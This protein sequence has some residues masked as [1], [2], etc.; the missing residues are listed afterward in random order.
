MSPSRTLGIELGLALVCL[1]CQTSRPKPSSP[2]V[3]PRA[4]AQSDELSQLQALEDRRS[5][6]DGKVAQWALTATDPRVRT[7]ALLALARIQDGSSV[8]TVVQA[9]GDAAPGPRLE[10]AFAAGILGRSWVA[11]SPAARDRLAAA[12]LT[13][14]A[15]ELD[16]PAKLTELEALGRVPTAAALERL[17]DRLDGT[18]PDVKAQAALSLGLA[19]KFEG[20]LPARVLAALVP[21]VRKDAPPTV[22]RA[23][24]YAFALSKAPG[25]R[26][27]LLVCLQDELPEVRALCA[28]GLGDVGTEPDAVPLK[29]LLGDSDYR[30]AVEATR[31]LAK[32]V[33]RCKTA[34]ACPGIAALG[35]LSARVQRLAQ[36]DSAGGG[37]PLLAL[38]QEGLP[39]SG[40][41]VLMAVRAKVQDALL[42]ATDARA[43]KDLAKIDCRLAAALDR[44]VG[45][46]DEVFACGGS[47]VPEPVRLAT[48]LHELA[49][50]KAID[51]GKRALELGPYLRHE[52]PR[53]KLAAL[54]AVGENG[55]PLS[56]A[57]VR[58]L[59]DSPDGVV[60]AAAAAT[61]GK[62]HDSAAVPGVRRL[63]V[64]VPAE[65]DLAENVA[66]ALVDLGAKEAEPELQ[67]WLRSPDASVRFAGA[68][69]LS[70]LTGKHVEAPRVERPAGAAQPPLLPPDT[71]AHFVTEK[72]NF[73]ARLYTE[74]A[75]RT[76]QNFVALAKKGFFRGLSF[77]RVVPDFVAQGGDPRGDG[78]GGPGYSV[79]CE[80]NRRP[81]ARGVLG[82]ALSGKDTG[83]S[84][85]FFT[86][87]AQ[88][89]LDGRY[90][91]FGE[92]IEGLEVVDA[93][94]EADGITDVRVTP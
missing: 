64:R 67:H 47:A 62:L 46:L 12:L 59:L 17:T 94:L 15:A 93:L 2:P 86:T 40:R 52:D 70:K 3:E 44:Q 84:Q 89:H 22:R 5:L 27:W 60:V 66:L 72:G 88:P 80:I 11:L 51:S 45:E 9:L 68:E 69:A 7:R 30:V 49:R 10:A 23:G 81:Y 50:N 33:A 74:D 1:A 57:G 24:A 92:V 76:S 28:K 26:P 91:A 20:A 73:A 25:A 71:V 61:A 85:F 37:Q 63:A 75:P 8:D 56:A 55:A 78:E 83:G 13:A 79:R 21:L 32:G 36:G 16:A 14:E 31:A 87:S 18:P 58:A 35:D 41:P 29:L 48:G 42:A 82:M 43:R 77:H 90:T 19:A 39:P 54:D 53:V 34:A 6:G 38:A 4:P 65:P